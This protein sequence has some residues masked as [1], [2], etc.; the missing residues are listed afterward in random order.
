MWSVRELIVAPA[1]VR[2]SGARAIVRLSGEGLERLLNSLFAVT[3]G[4]FVRQGEPPQLVAARLAAREL[5]AEWGELPVEL[6]HWPGPQG[7]T[8]GPLAEVQLPASGPLVDAVVAAACRHGARLAR[9]GEFSLRAFLAGRLDLLQAEAVL[10][11]VE[12]K[13]PAELS[14][15]LDSM[16]GGVGHTLHRLRETLLDL[17]ADIEASIDFADEH[18]PDAVP[19][20][21]AAA[22]ATIEA[23][24]A[25]AVDELDAVAARLAGRDSSAMA[26]L[27]RVVLVGPPNIGKSSLFNRLV[28]RDAALVADEPG[29]TR[30]W[31]AARLDSDATE[32]ACLLVDVAGIVDGVADDVV[33]TA[34]ARGLI[35]R[36]AAERARAEIARADVVV[37]C[38]DAAACVGTVLPPF[39]SDSPRIDV[40]TR[41]DLATPS[42][43]FE[44]AS[45]F[46][47][48]SRSGAG[49]AAVRSAILGAV[50]SLPGSRSPA[51]L[52]MRV[53]VGT[54]RE[55]VVAACAAA[56]STRSGGSR[57]E[58]IV[59]GLLHQA[60]SAV[61][62]V[63]GVEIGTDLIDRIFSRHC[64]GK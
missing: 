56:E 14:A 18:T 64:I 5:T 19:V 26:D 61:G 54:A 41:C 33:G 35:E 25:A 24:L 23:R 8:G 3:G 30:D 60:V 16:A 49:I 55:A 58:A 40:F 1:T 44:Y 32:P 51:T 43:C 57:D 63:T 62:E 6:I 27:P 45:A 38:S 47:T 50:A 46:E 36:A 7:P 59:A 13:T 52:R 34:A 48:S 31:I 22:W 29:T 28:G 9:G 10:A 12:A 39:P 20:A 42:P 21:D 37:V 4:G 11:V 2:G 15:A 17:T 53:G